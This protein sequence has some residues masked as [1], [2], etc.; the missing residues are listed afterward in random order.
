M[1]TSDWDSDPWILGTPGGYV[2][3]KTGEVSEADPSM[4]VSQLTSVSP[5]EKGTPTP[6]FSKFLDEV[7]QSDPALQRFLR[8]YLG[9]C[10]TGDTQEQVLLF[11]FGPGGNGKSVL[12]N[13]ANDIMG[14][15]AKTA[16]METFSAT[17]QQRHLTEIAMLRGA[18]LVCLSETEKGQRW[19]QPKINQMT[20]G[21]RI[22][23]NFM[24]QD[25]F[26]FKPTF[27]P[28]VVGK[29]LA[30]VNAAE[31]RRFLIVPFLHKPASPDKTLSTK[32]RA[33]YPAI[34]RWM[35]EGCLDWQQNGLVSPEVVALATK[36][37]FEEE[38]LFG[39]W[40]SECCVCGPCHK[41]KAKDL[42]ASYREYAVSNGE[43]AGS[44]KAVAE[45]LGNGGYKKTKSDG[46]VY[47]GIALKEAADASIADA[48]T[49]DAL[50][51]HEKDN[52]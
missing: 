7:T 49:T 32:L 13:V 9:Y 4:N 34:L 8:Q 18:R 35:I 46:I 17:R 2:S 33:E 20:G 23:A 48:P 16:A 25:M 22:T 3:L 45:M 21:D 30:S 12:Q 52:L 10:L 40:V 14:D 29:H 1:K 11:I 44:T 38:D 43:H 19:S 31:R 42:W 24:R 50:P 6:H 27:K 39:R 28:I 47:L 15:Y 5:A 37:Y 26:T 51:S 41:A 36:D